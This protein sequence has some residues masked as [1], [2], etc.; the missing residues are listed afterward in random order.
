[1]HQVDGVY[2]RRTFRGQRATRSSDKLGRQVFI[3]NSRATAEEFK[4]TAEVTKRRRCIINVLCQMYH[5]SN[6][7]LVSS[8]REKAAAYVSRLINGKELIG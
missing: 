8:L 5:V 2:A 3:K 1:M 6:I 4:S 7:S